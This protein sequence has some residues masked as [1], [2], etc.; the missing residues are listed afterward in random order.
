PLDLDGVDFGPVAE[1]EV[2]GLR[3]LR[4]VATGGGNLPDHDLFADVDRHQGADRLSIALGA[5]QLESDPIL[6]WE[7]VLEVVGVVV[8]VVG[9]DIE[10]AIAVEISN[11]YA[12]RAARSQLVADLL[13]QERALERRLD[14]R[15]TR[16]VRKSLI[17]IIHHQVVAPVEERVTHPR[18]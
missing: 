9:D 7:M 2:N 10:A 3:R 16:L 4:E 14:T 13:R 11:G 18:G 1:P 12:T 8:E 5:A 6:L 17:A 15:G